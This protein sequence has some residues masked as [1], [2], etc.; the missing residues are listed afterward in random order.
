MRTED[1]MLELILYVIILGI[2]A[3]AVQ[4]LPIAQPFK[5]VMF[6]LLLIALVIALFR[7]IPV[8]LPDLR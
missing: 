2:L 8:L 7:A 5:T 6:A 1:E 4:A 3:W